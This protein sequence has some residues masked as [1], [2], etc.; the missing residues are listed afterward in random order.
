MRILIPALGVCLSAALW[1][2]AQAA[3]VACAPR[4]QVM[5]DL[6]RK[7]N[8]AP[9]AM[10]LAGDGNLVE[11]LTAPDG[12]TWTLVLTTPRGMSCLFAAGQFWEGRN[13]Q[14]VLPAPDHGNGIRVPIDPSGPEM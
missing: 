13:N 3:E 7:Y 14:L 1:T 12:Q 5:A 2:T 8:E 10:G 4:D 9:A 6:A 11:L